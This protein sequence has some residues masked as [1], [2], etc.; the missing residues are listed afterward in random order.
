MTYYVI[1]INKE[2]SGTPSQAIFL[3]DRNDGESDLD[4]LER[5]KSQWHSSCASAGAN[6]DL[7]YWCRGLV[8]ETMQMIIKD[9]SAIA[10][11]EPV[12]ETTEGE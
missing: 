1:E 2:K 5:A 11:A 3:V 7:E 8:D 6:P 12:E 9:L 10:P 4:Y